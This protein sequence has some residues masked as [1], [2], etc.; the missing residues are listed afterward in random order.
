MR[1]RQ[2]PNRPRRVSPSTLD[3]RAQEAVAGFVRVLARCG[4]T[5][6]Q[7]S[8]EVLKA[9]RRVPRSSTQTTKAAVSEIEA[10]AHVLTLWFQEPTYVDSTGNPKPLS[11]R[12]GERSLDALV[13]RVDPDLDVERILGHLLRYSVLRRI[14]SRYLPRDRALMLHS[15]ADYHARSLQTLGAMLSA[16]EHNSRPRRSTFGWFERFAVNARVP[17]TAR[18]NFDEWLRREGTRL[19]ERADVKLHGYERKRRKGERTVRIGVGLYRIGEEALP[20]KR[21]TR[22]RIPRRK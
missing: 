19:L 4:C 9:C 21:R 7:I 10:A 22:R 5:P 1:R 13:R 2:A 12:D 14:G 16:L 11:V 18:A 3:A 6:E 17:A 20:P 8:E 15:G